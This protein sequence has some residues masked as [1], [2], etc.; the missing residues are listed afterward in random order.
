[1]MI[2]ATLVYAIVLAQA[3]S[4]DQEALS[5]M[6]DLGMLM[7]GGFVLAVATAIGLTVIRLKLRD[8]KPE[9]PKFVSISSRDDE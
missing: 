4:S 1:M 2:V 3:A 9:A 7:L 8:K 5:D 6:N